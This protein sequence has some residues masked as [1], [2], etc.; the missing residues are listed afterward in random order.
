[1]VFFD[2]TTAIVTS[3]LRIRRACNTLRYST[4]RRP[5]QDAVAAHNWI[6]P[7]QYNH[8]HTTLTAGCQGFTGDAA[9]IRQG[10]NFLSLISPMIMASKAYQDHSGIIIW[11]DESEQDGV[12]GDNPDDFDH[13]IRETMISEDARQSA[14]KLFA[15]PVNFI[16]SS[17]L[18]S[19]EN[20]FH[21]G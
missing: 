21:V 10:D 3:A 6:T 16:H 19:M 20:I 11:F 9:K 5:D 15:S 4:G 18:R 1:M 2:D 17:D 14:G 7:D 12:A 13:N 8:M